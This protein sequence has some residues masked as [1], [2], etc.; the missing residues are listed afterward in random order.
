MIYCL[1]ILMLMMFLFTLFKLRQHRLKL[2][3]YPLI[4]ILFLSA[5]LTISYFFKFFN[6]ALTIS[7]FIILYM[8]IIFLNIGHKI[9][10]TYFTLL[11]SCI[12]IT[13]G[14]AIL[15]KEYKYLA[16][17]LA[18]LIFIL[19]ENKQTYLRKSY[20]DSC[21]EY[22]QKIL[23]K[24]IE[25]VQGIYLKMRGWRHDYHNHLQSIKAYL[26]LQEYQEAIKYLNDLEVDLKDVNALVETGNVDLDA[27]INAKLSVAIDHKIKLNYKINV[28]SKLTISNIDLCVLLGNLVDNA[29][30]ACDKTTDKFMRLYIGLFKNQLYISVTNSTNEVVRKFDNEY[31]TTKRGNHGHGL[32][33]INNIVAKYDGFINR[34]NEPGVFVTEVMLPL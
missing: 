19:S 17:I 6:L 2:I 32:K 15:M 16:F 4:I 21:N 12:S 3:C 11:L 20:E 29:V 14:I 23:N 33:R 13:L 26:S 24:Q 18:F 27:I 7:F 5:F 1:I 22:Q 25:E 34:K 8:S 10:I 30:E 31:I 28:P 9:S